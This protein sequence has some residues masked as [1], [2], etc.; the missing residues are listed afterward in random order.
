MKP[1]TFALA[2]V[3]GIYGGAGLGYAAKSAY[4]VD[5]LALPE[6]DYLANLRE[7]S[8][9]GCST[10][11]RR[12]P[13]L[14][15]VGDS[16]SYTAWDYQRI[17]AAYPSARIGACTMGGA[18]VE[19]VASMVALLEDKQIHPTLIVYGT[20]PRQ[21]A[22]FADKPE[23]LALQRATIA[24]HYTF[25]DFV[26]DLLRHMKTGHRTTQ[27]HTSAAQDRLAF[28]RTDSALATVDPV[29]ADRYV[30]QFHND[31]FERWSVR[32][33]DWHAS[34]NTADAIA[35][36]CAFT[37]QRHV[38]LLIVRIP[39]SPTLEAMYPDSVT[40]HY[41]AALQQ[42]RRCATVVDAPGSAWPLDS[43][44]FMNRTLDSAY[45]YANMRAGTRL[46]FDVKARPNY[47]YDLDHLNVVGAARFT[48]LVLQ[49]HLLDPAR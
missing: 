26:G 47:E 33:A 20:S 31:S 13:D 11:V 1:R 22:E 9:F 28:L 8:T 7:S 19:T 21:F 38:R 10:L 30:Q 5:Y 37:E 42:F 6:A 34:A 18:Y 24:S 15:F 12:R 41:V 40:K 39:E 14:L 4:P 45:S 23:A 29:D 48:D 35:R 36:I 2:C 25:R 44:H 43:R 17:A 32:L 16:H 49:R 27:V 3:M 46:T